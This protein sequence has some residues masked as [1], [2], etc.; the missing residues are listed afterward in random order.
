MAA[1]R[2]TG[3]GR[4]WYTSIK[5]QFAS[6]AAQTHDLGRPPMAVVTL[7]GQI[8][9][10]GSEVGL[11]VA[12]HL[13]ADYVDRLILAEA[14]KRIG[15]TVQAVAGK[16]SEVTSR[17]DLLGRF[18]QNVLERSA[19]SGAGGEPYFGPGVDVLLSRDY[20]SEVEDEP[21]TLTHEV[22]DKKYIEVTTAVIKDLA[23][24]GN[25]VIVGRASNLILRGDPGVLHV[26]IV[27]PLE[28]RIHTI[29]KREHLEY[30]NAHRFVEDHEQARKAYFSKFYDVDTDDP[31]I[32]H[33]IINMADLKVGTAGEIVAHA[34]QDL[35]H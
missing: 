1:L 15:A 10:G 22:D 9:S 4:F 29:M 5:A 14:A 8:G 34:A 11:Q 35:T 6:P 21:I 17:R 25:V 12:H 27:A 24:E 33:M 7:N 16:E 31:N 18:F 20:Y 26:G 32:Y 30:A 19:M 2:M 13:H 28:H 3:E 23:K